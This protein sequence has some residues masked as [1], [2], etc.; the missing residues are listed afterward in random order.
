MKFAMTMLCLCLLFTGAVGSADE[1]TT[2]LLQVSQG[3][4]QRSSD[5]GAHALNASV[6]PPDHEGSSP[7]Y[8]QV[9][10]GTC[11]EA[12]ASLITDAATCEAAAVALGLQDTTITTVTNM[13]DRPPG[14]TYHIFNNL[15][16]FTNVWGDKKCGS[17]GGYTCLCEAW[18]SAPGTPVPHV[19]LY[20]QVP[21]GTCAAVGLS[22]I[23]D[24]STCR[25]AAIS[26][27]LQDTTVTT[28][29]NMIDRPPGCT[30]HIYNN[31]EM[32]TNVYGDKECGSMGGY[33]CLC[34]K[35]FTQVT[36]GTC[37]AVGA[38]VITD[39]ATCEEAATSLG[40]QDT[41]VTL[42]TNNIDRPH[43]CTYHQFQNLEL[44]L[45]TYGNKECGDP[46]TPHYSCLCQF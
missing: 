12:K 10:S 4:V 23:N 39:P 25:E 43:G 28:V 35:R 13:I 37:A 30:Y 18:P 32:F 11:A 8:V 14:C 46:T 22:L 33:T 5:R 41:T 31:L 34:K 17:M 29:T 1:D 42:V 21:T 2:A 26:L 36:S 3:A 27:G 20:T 9:T 6:Q 44:F 16:M 38:T 40:K 7:T 45:Q 19:S 15:E 24:A